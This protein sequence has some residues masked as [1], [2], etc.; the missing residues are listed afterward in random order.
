MLELRPS[1]ISTTLGRLEKL[2]EKNK[3]FLLHLRRGDYLKP[4]IQGAL[5]IGYYLRG[6]EA[7]G[8]KPAD[9]L[10]LLSDSPEIAAKEF[11]GSGYKN[12]LVVGIDVDPLT[13][14][15]SLWLASCARNLVMSNSTFSWWAAATGYLGKRV[16]FPGGW[17]D[18]IMEKSWTRIEADS[19]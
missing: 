3:T 6:L 7:L 12:I 13:A 18:Y 17:N 16:A 5:P 9:T 2:V 14:P 15:E 4:S 11:S 1:K 10:I 8:A 19:S